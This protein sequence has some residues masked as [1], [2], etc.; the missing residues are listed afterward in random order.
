MNLGVY[1]YI[2]W[3][4][5][6]NTFG[7]LAQNEFLIYNFY[8]ESGGHVYQQTVGIPKGTN[9]APLVADLFLYAYE[10]DFV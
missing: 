4:H 6:P 7:V 3:F 5:I 2:V 1:W 8:V 10:A 9:C